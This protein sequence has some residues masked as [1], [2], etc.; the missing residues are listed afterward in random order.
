MSHPKC[1]TTFIVRHLEASYTN[2]TSDMQYA[3]IYIVKTCSCVCRQKENNVFIIL[4]LNAE[5]MKF[6]STFF[7]F[8]FMTKISSNF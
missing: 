7:G 8:P 5:E 1:C 2:A 6:T 3:Q 4:L